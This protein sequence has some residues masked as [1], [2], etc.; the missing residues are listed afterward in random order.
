MHHV[1]WPWLSM[2]KVYRG[3]VEY[4]P[5]ET[6]VSVSPPFGRE[7]HEDDDLVQELYSKFNADRVVILN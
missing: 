5:D 6:I 1:I 3:R 4:N 2:T 7:V